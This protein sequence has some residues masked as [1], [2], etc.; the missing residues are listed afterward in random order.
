MNDD[1]AYMRSRSGPNNRWLAVLAALGVAGLLIVIFFHDRGVPIAAIDFKVRQPEAT[2]VAAAYL[3]QVG[4]D[5][6]G[7]QSA[8]S[9][10]TDRDAQG[11]VER[12]AGQRELD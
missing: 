2:G 4:F 9:F 1:L 7:F 6:S 8:V 3:K 12:T 11:Y 10:E 5:L